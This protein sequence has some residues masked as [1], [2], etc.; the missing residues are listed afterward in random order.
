MV[1]K[2]CLGVVWHC[3]GGGGESVCAPGIG[4]VKA[5]SNDEE[6]PFAFN[7]SG[8]SGRNP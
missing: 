3:D 8:R 4:L 5:C 2:E 6:Y 7:L 1:L